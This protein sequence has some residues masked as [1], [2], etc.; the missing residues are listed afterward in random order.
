MSFGRSTI[1]TSA[2]LTN[3]TVKVFNDPENFIAGRVAPRIPGTVR[4]T[5]SYYIYSRSNLRIDG[6]IKGRGSPSKS[7]TRD[8]DST[9]YTTARYGGRMIA[10]DD[11][12]DEADVSIAQMQQDD[13]EE[14]A[15]KLALDYEL[16]VYTKVTTSGN[17]ASGHSI[18]LTDEWDDYVN[19]DPIADVRT[20]REQVRSAIGR[21]PNYMAMAAKDFD[22]L[23][24]HPDIRELYVYTGGMAV[25][26]STT[27]VARVLGLTDILVSKAVYVSSD[28][29]QATDTQGDI[30]GENAV[31][32]YSGAG[33]GRKSSH[34][35]RTFISQEM[36]TR[37]YRDE[38]VEG[39]WTDSDWKYGLGFINVDNTTDLKATGGYLIANIRS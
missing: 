9:T 36:R 7:F 20:G 29:G 6:T 17:Y 32:F 22:K 35:L 19:G 21:Y 34:F 18:S 13:A 16:A 24:Y 5:G 2:P 25:D 28:E 38:E 27:M 33:M 37:S 10:L 4:V 39:T 11:D 3:L 8:L 12:V 26:P 1:H 14:I 15:E 31:L 23:K 30:W